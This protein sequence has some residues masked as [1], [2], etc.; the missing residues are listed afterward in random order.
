MFKDICTSEIV[1]NSIDNFYKEILL[2][3]KFTGNYPISCKK[4]S[5]NHD[6]NVFLDYIVIKN[7]SGKTIFNRQETVEKNKYILNPLSKEFFD[8][9]IYGLIS[10]INSLLKEYNDNIYKIFSVN[11]RI[12]G[13]KKIMS[14]YYIYVDETLEVLIN[15][16]LL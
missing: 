16:E 7:K 5:L 8:R 3:E 15:L 2:K 6:L 10:N 9:N 14:I 13:N 11:Y 12:K 1:E 4:L